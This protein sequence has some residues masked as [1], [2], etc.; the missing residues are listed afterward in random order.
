MAV[1]LRF[2]LRSGSTE[3]F[4]DKTRCK[5]MQEDRYVLCNGGSV[6]NVKYWSVKSLIRIDVGFWKGS[7]EL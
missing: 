5:M 1:R 7:R 4:E 3:L 2:R 6:E